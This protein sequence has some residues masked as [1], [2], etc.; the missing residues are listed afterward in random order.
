MR[1]VRNQDRICALSWLS[2]DAT[3]D[4][5]R[6]S[7]VSVRLPGDEVECSIGWKRLD[8]KL[9]LHPH[10]HPPATERFHRDGGW[11][12]PSPAVSGK[13]SHGG[14]RTAT[15]YPRS[16][17]AGCFR[18]CRAPLARS[19][20]FAGIAESGG[21]KF[22]FHRFRNAFITVAKRALMPP[23]SLTRRQINHARPGDVT[24][25]YTPDRTVE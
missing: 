13:S 24:R 9:P 6:C 22:W 21:V 25:D 11:N 10:S 3:G 17:A 7:A 20:S 5:S 8:A 12:C 2:V 23:R 16:C 18:R 15:P 14:G 19:R 4:C 1:F